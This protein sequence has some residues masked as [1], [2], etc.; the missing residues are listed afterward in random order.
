MSDHVFYE[1]NGYFFW[2]FAAPLENGKWEAFAW[3]ERKIDHANSL[4]HGVKMRLK[5]EFNSEAEALDAVTQDAFT[6]A[7]GDD[8]PF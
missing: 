3:F 7:K 4:V 5:H 6:R 1:E 8:V 2:V